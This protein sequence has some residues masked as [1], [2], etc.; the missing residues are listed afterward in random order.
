METEATAAIAEVDVPYLR[1]GDSDLLAR[2]YR[3]AGTGPFP[4]LVEI[5][6]GAWTGNDRFANA[7]I[8]RD[9]AANGIV[10]MSIDFRMPPQAGYPASIRDANFAIRWLKANAEQFDVDPAKIGALGTS[11]GAHQMLLTAL[12]PA[13]PDFAAIPLPRTDANLRF[14]VACWPVA[15][16]LKRYRMAQE[17]G[18]A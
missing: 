4:G 17:R 2:I 6:G 3:P 15:D 13:D 10:V 11:S 5:H 12:R 1:S 7:A 18:L 14:A 9:L 8:G 16:P